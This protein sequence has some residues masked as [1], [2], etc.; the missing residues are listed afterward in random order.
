MTVIFVLFLA[1]VAVILVKRFGT[2]AV[3]KHLLAR[4]GELLMKVVYIGVG[5]Y[6]FYDSGLLRHLLNLV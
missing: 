6:V 5:L 1:A 2:L 4:Y 3:V